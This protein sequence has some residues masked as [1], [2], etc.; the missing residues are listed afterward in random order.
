MYGT[1]WPQSRFDWH[2]NLVATITCEIG[3]YLRRFKKALIIIPPVLILIT[4]AGF[5]ASCCE[6]CPTCPGPSKPYKGW[7]YATDYNNKWLYM[8]DTDTDS[9]MDSANYVAEKSYI[10]SAIDVSAD[11][12]YLAVGYYILAPTY[13]GLIR[14]YDAQTLEVITDL[15]DLSI[16]A[17]VSDE[18]ILLGVGSG[19]RIYSIP[20]FTLIRYDSSNLGGFAAID[21]DNHLAYIPGA[22]NPASSESTYVAAYD[23]V[24]GVI[25]DQWFI[26]DS[27]DEVANICTIEINPDG[28]RLYSIT[29]SWYDG[30]RVTCYDLVERETLFWRDIY[31]QTGWLELSP[32]GKEIYVTDPGYFEDINTPGTVYVIDADDGSYIEGISLFGY[33]PS[34]TKPLSAFPIIFTPT[35]DKA[36]VGSGRGIGLKSG[37][38]SVIDTQTRDI[39]ENIWPDLGHS[40]WQLKVGSKL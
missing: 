8:I 17:F 37:T 9:V 20:D 12:R 2:D 5:I 13:I 22:M 7:L 24:Q 3:G 30:S 18:N 35:G 6:D 26:K 39:V 29:G 40:I 31:S 33:G 28:R 15:P 16:P 14:I 10:P 38:I 4:L 34:I 23:Y 36:Y 19:V 11:G 1:P 25:V 32:A 21:E 27:Q